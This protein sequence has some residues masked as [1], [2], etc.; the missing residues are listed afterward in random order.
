MKGGGARGGEGKEESGGTPFNPAFSDALLLPNLLSNCRCC[1]YWD[2]TPDGI[3]VRDLTVKA[4]RRLTF[5]LT[6]NF[7]LNDQ[8][9]NLTWRLAWNIQ[10]EAFK[11]M[12]SRPSLVMNQMSRH[13]SIFRAQLKPLSRY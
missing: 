11:A 3:R 10:F 13:E 8:M 9:L 6:V 4:S 2:K 1:P 7:T 12:D 5:Q